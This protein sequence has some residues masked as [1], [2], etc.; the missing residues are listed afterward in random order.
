M[1]KNF[2]FGKQA[3]I[4]AGS[5]NFAALLTAAP[6]T[7]GLV[8]SQATAFAT[9]NTALQT[10]YAA[11][12]SPAT[13][14][15]TAVEANRQAIENMRKT[16]ILYGKIITATPTVT[17]AQ[18]VALGLLPRSSPAPRP[19]PLI[20]PVL[21]IVSVVNRLVTIK[22]RPGGSDSRSKPNGTAGAQVFS[23]SGPTA[24]SDPRL[25]HYEGLATRGTA[26]VQFPDTI[27]NG[28]TVWLAAGWVTQRGLPCQACTPVQVII[29]GGAVLPQAA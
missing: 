1:A 17:D 21:T 14:T 8:A 7:Y 10:A 25:Y 24:P 22:I 6:T 3:D 16:A 12:I 23:Y 18:L 28:S 27:A 11:A 15:R 19:I 20:P 29:Q 2:Y 5:A 26:Q 9:L 13:R 4:V